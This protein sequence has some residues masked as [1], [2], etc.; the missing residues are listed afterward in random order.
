MPRDEFSQATK[1]TL[2]R[3]VNYRCSLCGKQTVG[4]QTDPHKSLNIGVAAHITAA[5]EGGPRWDPSLTHEQRCSIQNGIWMCQDHAKLV[6]SDD[7]RYTAAELRMLKQRAENA[8]LQALEQLASTRES[9]VRVKFR[10][11]QVIE[12]GP[13]SDRDVIHLDHGVRFIELE[14]GPNRIRLARLLGPTSKI[15]EV[16]GSQNVY[17][18]PLVATHHVDEHSQQVDALAFQPHLPG[19][20]FGIGPGMT[21]THDFRD[22]DRVF[23]IELV[24]IVDKST[25]EL[26]SREY[27]FSIIEQ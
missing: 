2:A 4:P 27:T 16:R 9:V 8:A 23:R 13:F 6:D 20:E 10:D 25:P 22:N 12:V 14:S 21:S 15:N 11:T 3:R 18:G 26:P 5:A 24:S 7:S 1:D 17:V 19:R